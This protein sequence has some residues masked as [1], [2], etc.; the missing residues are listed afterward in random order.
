MKAVFFYLPFTLL[1]VL[2]VAWWPRA[3]ALA[4]LAITTIAGGVIA[5]GVALFQYA[6]REIWWNETLCSRPT[7]TAASSA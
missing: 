5:A 2:V 7:S 6:T 3:R 1:Y 4:A